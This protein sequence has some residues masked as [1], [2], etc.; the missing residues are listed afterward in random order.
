MTDQ[1]FNS[2]REL[3]YHWEAQCKDGGFIPDEDG[4]RIAVTRTRR[5]AEELHELIQA[6][7]V[8]QRLTN[9]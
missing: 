5:C 4:N 9:K 8:I 3:A 7:E 1:E 6:L 2:L